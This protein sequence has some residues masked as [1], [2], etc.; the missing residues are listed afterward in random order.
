VSFGCPRVQRTS[1]ALRTALASPGGL[2]WRALQAR[3]LSPIAGPRQAS[4]R[5]RHAFS[6]RSSPV[7]RVPSTTYQ[8]WA[9]LKAP[10]EY[11]QSDGRLIS[12]SHTD[13][14]NI[15]FHESD[16]GFPAAIHRIRLPRSIQEPF[17]AFA[18]PESGDRL[19]CPCVR[20]NSS[21]ERD[22]GRRFAKFERGFAAILRF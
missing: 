10:S 18:R 1:E 17:A 9:S 8:Q 4:Q 22:T 16:Q 12:N 2:L 19:G 5:E 6:A 3:R 21:R 11:R 13:R 20:T 7:P 15:D 14:R